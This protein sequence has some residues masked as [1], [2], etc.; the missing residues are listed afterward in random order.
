MALTFFIGENDLGKDIKRQ[1]IDRNVK[2]Q[3]ASSLSTEMSHSGEQQ[4]GWGW[5]QGQP[6]HGGREVAPAG[7]V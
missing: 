4:P 1:G 5:D 7:E 2:G 6:G 3:K